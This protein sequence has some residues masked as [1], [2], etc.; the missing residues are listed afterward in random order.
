MTSKASIDRRQF[1]KRTAASVSAI[2]A[3]PFFSPD[4]VAR[5]DELALLDGL[6]QAEMIRKRDISTL[7]LTRA[8]VERIEKSE[9][10]VNALVTETFDAAI[11]RARTGNVGS[12]PFAGVPYLIKEL[13]EYPGLPQTFGSRHF[14]KNMGRVEHPYVRRTRQAGFN[15][16]GTS[17]SPEFGLLATT[18]SL[19]NGPT[20]N[21]WNR[22]HSPG[23]SSGG[24]AAAV[25]AGMVPL[26]HASD[27]GGSIRIPAS[28]CGV[29]G[30][31]PS[32]SRNVP[33]RAGQRAADISV[34]HCVSRSV[35]DSAMLLSLTE[36]RGR[37]ARLN[38]V[39]YISSP[40]V[41]RL[42]IAVSTRN[43]FQKRP[44]K[45]VRQAIED[46]AD[47][48]EDLGH[49]V[50]DDMIELNG[51]E[52]AEHFLVVWASGPAQIIADYKKRYGKL[53]DDSVFESWTLGLAEHFNAKPTDALQRALDYFKISSKDRGSV[54][55]SVRCRAVTNIVYTAAAVGRTRPRRP[56]W[57]IVRPGCRLCVVHPP[58]QCCRHAGNVRATPLDE[59]R[60]ARRKSVRSADGRRSNPSTPGI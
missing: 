10:F 8:T 24:A 7:E 32:R 26:A 33:A 35:R 6:G 47:L 14:A 29:F 21:P 48:C 45:E 57:R 27:G 15:V 42:R 52:F 9:P 18:E 31:K 1:V 55:S 34:G 5:T 28:C 37:A 3:A 22:G 30:L 2:A 19:L 20:R 40:N 17:A 44:H 16:L 38:P 50:D 39:G 46:T 41:R 13:Q 4:A 56:V 54:S 12:G 59:R 43:T 58:T 25:A 49:D 60:F 11:R 53:P 51:E 36:A 23:G